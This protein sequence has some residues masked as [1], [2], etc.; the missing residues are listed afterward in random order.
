MLSSINCLTTG[1]LSSITCLTTGV[2]SSINVSHKLQRNHVTFIHIMRSGL[3]LHF[4]LNPYITNLMT[5]IQENQENTH[6]YINI[7]SIETRLSPN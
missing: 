2:L 7:Y 6:M 3:T 5:L 1:V 4:G